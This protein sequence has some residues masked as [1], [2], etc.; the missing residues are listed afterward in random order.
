MEKG[1]SQKNL[2]S[3][4]SSRNIKSRHTGGRT[5]MFAHHALTPPQPIP[6]FS[7]AFFRGTTTPPPP[8]RRPSSSSSSSTTTFG[9][10][11]TVRVSATTRRGTF[12]GAERA[13]NL[14]LIF[15]NAHQYD[16]PA[17]VVRTHRGGASFF[18]GGVSRTTTVAKSV[19]EKSS[20]L[21]ILYDPLRSRVHKKKRLLKVKSCKAIGRAVKG[22]N[23]PFITTLMLCL[24]VEDVVASAPGFDRSLHRSNARREIHARMTIDPFQTSDRSIEILS[25]HYISS[26]RKGKSPIY[27]KNEAKNFQRH[28]KLTTTFSF[29]SPLSKRRRFFFFRRTKN[30]RRVG[31][32]RRG[33]G[34][35]D[36]EKCRRNQEI[37]PKTNRDWY[38]S[39]RSNLFRRRGHVPSD[40]ASR[41]RTTRRKMERYVRALS[42]GKPEASVL[43]FHGIFAR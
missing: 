25:F 43:Y 2:L 23:L 1:K 14:V 12:V 3:S 24:S 13:T 20:D 18:E 30:Q 33:K 15:E 32:R 4:S 39:D 6:I 10:G 35:R 17:F 42:Q 5:M 40:G 9:F 34:H 41:S 29:I 8:R 31:V 36:P 19:V 21:S 38:Y 27:W 37:H 7:S 22:G 26:F 16:V 11:S 28:K